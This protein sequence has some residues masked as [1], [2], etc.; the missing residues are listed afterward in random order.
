MTQ[1]KIAQQLQINQSSIS[2]ELKRNT[3]KRGY[4]AKQADNFAH[5]RKK[6]TIKNRVMTEGMIEKIKGC[7]KELGVVLLSRSKIFL[8]S[9][10]YKEVK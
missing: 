5:L 10:N 7:L 3:G 9:T 1:T 8:N 6:D 2:R 4:R